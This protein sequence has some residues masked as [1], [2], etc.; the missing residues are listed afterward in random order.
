MTFGLWVLLL[1]DALMLSGVIFFELLTGT[2]P[3]DAD[4]PA[5]VFA[6]ILNFQECMDEI[7][8]LAPLDLISEPARDLLKKLICEPEVRIGRR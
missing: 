3:F 7:Y 2:T 8:K 5:E 1:K 4:S 6:N